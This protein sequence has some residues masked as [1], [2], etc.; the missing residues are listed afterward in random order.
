[1]AEQA[2]RGRPRGFETVGDMVR[3]LAV[4]LGAVLVIL[5]ITLR[6]QPD[7]V[8]VVDATQ[9]RQAAAAVAS[10]QPADPERPPAGWRLTSARFTPAVVSRSG[11]SV[12]HLG[13]VTK[14][15]RYA[16]LE[17][18]DGPAEPLLES[19]LTTPVDAGPGKGAF[20]GWERWTGRPSSWQA[21]V[22]TVGK[23]TLV[24]VGSADDAELAR[25]AASLQLSS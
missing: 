3:S 15:G 9:A 19:I 7:G 13:W 1:M 8:K 17:Q 14:A 2:G 11:F 4:V 22:K 18:S 12:W 10:F 24:V 5:L 25:L 23:T 21:Y 16:S 20:V 6:P